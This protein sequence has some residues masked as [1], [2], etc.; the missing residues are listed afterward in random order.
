MKGVKH[1][2]KNGAEYKGKTHKHTSGKLMTGTKHTPSSK[3][4]V[5]KK[6]KK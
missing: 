4:L 6:A 1:Y 3:P 2:L 5:H